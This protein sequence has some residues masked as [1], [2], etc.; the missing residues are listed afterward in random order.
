MTD[1]DYQKHLVELATEFW[2]LGKLYEK[3]VSDQD[4]VRQPKGAAQLRY[5]WGKM[6]SILENAG[7]KV[8]TYDGLS[9]EAN[10]PVTVANLDDLAGEERLVVISTL[11]PTLLA[12]GKV[13]A[14]GKVALARGI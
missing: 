13:M 12:G 8:V 14:M 4:V 11:E 6:A 5:A 1:P 9:Y 2:R 7:I 10:L 3:A